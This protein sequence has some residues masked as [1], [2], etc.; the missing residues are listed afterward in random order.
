VNGILTAG[1]PPIPA[2]QNL[3]CAKSVSSLKSQS[4]RPLLCRRCDFATCLAFTFLLGYP[5]SFLQCCGDFALAVAAPIVP[6][7]SRLRRFHRTV[8]DVVEE[9]DG[10]KVVRQHYSSYE[11]NATSI[12]LPTTA[13]GLNPTIVQESSTTVETH[14]GGIIFS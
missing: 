2:P 13:N 14:H 5:H 8:V 9:A 10:D 4:A 3:P 6:S 1:A 11:A 7:H 12:R